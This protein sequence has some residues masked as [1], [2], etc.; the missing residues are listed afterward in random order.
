MRDRRKSGGIEA[1]LHL[2]L[3]TVSGRAAVLIRRLAWTRTP[4]L[5][6]LGSR[7]FSTVVI[8][9]M[10]LA[11]RPY[12]PVLQ[13]QHNPFTAWDGQ[14]Y[15]WIAAH[16]YSASPVHGHLDYAFYP[17]WPVL[18]SLLPFPS[19]RWLEAVILANLL[20][21]AAAI[22]V[23]R[24]LAEAFDR[25][26][27]TGG[28]ALLAFAPPSFVF[29]LIYSESLFVL[30][31]AGSLLAIRRAAPGSSAV[32]GFLVALARVTGV[33]VAAAG[34]VAVLRRGPRARAG[35][36][37]AVGVGAAIGAWLAF[38]QWLTGDAI[39]FINVGA[40]WVP[41]TSGPA[42]IARD[43]GGLGTDKLVRAA[44]IIIVLVASFALVR[45]DLELAAYAL[46][47]DA[48][49]IGFGATWSI[50]RY[51]LVAFPAFGVIAA[52]AGRRGTVAL[53]VLSAALEIAFTWMSIS[54]K[55]I[56]GI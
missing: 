32:G 18:L 51:V 20:F 45:V 47:C 48:I 49:G 14:W 54:P 50:P 53:V 28:T 55:P 52:R 39:R 4:L 6:G 22:L 30:L 31:A 56:D 41:G 26:T 38:N 33:A 16:G 13:G 17:L 29:S 37:A 2:V 43:F 36:A 19:I 35:L 23:W 25:R 27:A 5:I 12:F 15:L 24:V 10:I 8:A 46:V 1:D 7:L 9:A 42:A 11:G 34:L 21:V 40:T 3:A 44:F